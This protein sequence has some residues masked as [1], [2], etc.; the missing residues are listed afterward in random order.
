MGILIKLF[1]TELNKRKLRSSQSRQKEKKSQEKEVN[2]QWKNHLQ[3]MLTKC[4][5]FSQE[6]INTQISPAK[7]KIE[8]SFALFQASSARFSMSEKRKKKKRVE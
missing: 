1:C 2:K 4:I 5:F 3:W 7:K 8:F 6:Y